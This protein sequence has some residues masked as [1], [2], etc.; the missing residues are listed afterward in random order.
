MTHFTPSK[1][2]DREGIFKL[3][4]HWA[5]QQRQERRKKIER[6]VFAVLMTAGALYFLVHLVVAFEKGWL[7]WAW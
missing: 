6:R 1:R 5:Q 2:Y 7:V 4:E 3:R